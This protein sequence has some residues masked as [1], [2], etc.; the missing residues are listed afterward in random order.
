MNTC[1]LIGNLTRDPEKKATQSGV[2]ACSFTIAV[3]RPKA[4]DGTQQADYFNIIT[5]RTLAENCARYLAKGKKVGVVGELR[6][7]SYEKDGRKVYVTEIQANSVEF[8][9]PLGQ[10]DSTGEAVH[11]PGIN[12]FTQVNDDDLPF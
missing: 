7:R 9:T 5:W 12:S 2:A 10:M 8:L 1:I 11:Q 4:K 3:N 6:T